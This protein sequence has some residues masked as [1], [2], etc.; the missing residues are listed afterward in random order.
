MAIRPFGGR[1]MSSVRLQRKSDE[2]DESLQD[3]SLEEER[4]QD[5]TSV[6]LSIGTLEGNG[7]TANDV[8]KL[9]EHGFYTVESVVYATQKHICSIK[10]IS[11]A[12]ADKVIIFVEFL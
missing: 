3:S 12:K 5:G 11:E 7:I 1:V 2:Q 9:K 10:G 6:V 8:S 4:E